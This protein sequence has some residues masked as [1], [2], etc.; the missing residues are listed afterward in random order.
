MEQRQKSK[1]HRDDKKKSKHL[2]WAPNTARL[3]IVV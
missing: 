2:F 3:N 1:Y